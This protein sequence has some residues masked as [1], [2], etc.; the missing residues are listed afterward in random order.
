MPLARVAEAIEEFR[1]GRA[2]I[3]VDERGDEA[4]GNFAVAAEK[5]TPDWVN[6]MVKHGRGL[7]YLTLTESRARELELAPMDPDPSSP[8]GTAFTVSIEA[9]RGVTTGISAADRATTILTAINPRSSSRDL[10]RPGHVFP[11]I[12]R[13]GGVL[14]RVG[15]TEASVDLARLARLRPGGVICEILSD[16]GSVAGRLD[17][18][19][20]AKEFDL[21]IISIVDLIAFRRAKD[22]LVSRYVELDIDYVHGRFH[23]IVYRSEVGD[24]EHVAF[25]KGNV[26]DGQPVLVRMQTAIPAAAFNADLGIPSL[27][28]APMRRIESEGRG[29]IVII[30]QPGGGERVGDTFKRM[31]A[32]EGA[33]ALPRNEAER[34][35]DYGLGAQ[36]LGDLG[37]QRIRLLSNRPRRIVGLEGFDLSVEETV[38]L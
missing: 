1:R 16:D 28:A 35:R 17:L 34:I 20:F 25:T 19:R 38:P 5:I 26:A 9:R 12:A 32:A 21:K 18:E 29:A 31:I 36:I 10:V 33:Q 8:R 4:E 22:K 3:I 7:V 13:S 30:G 23:T 11:L 2:V 24:G 14:V 27:L 37:V 6:F 15:H